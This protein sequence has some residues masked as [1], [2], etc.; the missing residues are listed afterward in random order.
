M[1]IENL[2]SEDQLKIIRKL[3]KN[4]ED[5][6]YYWPEI[7]ECGEIHMESLTK[8]KIECKFYNV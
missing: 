2:S 7:Y 8:Y 3:Y 4:F 5:L 6:L 1:E